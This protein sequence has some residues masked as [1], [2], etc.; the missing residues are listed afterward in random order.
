MA[1]S[2]HVTPEDIA[3]LMRAKGIETQGRPRLFPVNGSG[4]ALVGLSAVFPCEG[5]FADG[6]QTTFEEVKHGA[7]D[8]SREVDLV[9]GMIQARIEQVEQPED[10]LDH[11][12]V[13]YV[14]LNCA[15]AL[16][17]CHN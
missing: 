16:A 14:L 9:R 7:G 8:V 4:E 17:G 5:E 3:L 2:Y 1:R 6:D 12:P 10:W 11:A 15:E 13:L